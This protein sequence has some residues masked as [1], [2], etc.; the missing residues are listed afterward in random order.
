MIETSRTLQ[1]VEA[2]IEL[3][4]L[5]EPELITVDDDSP[6]WPDNIADL[7][8]DELAHHM[9]YWTGLGAYGR[10]HLARCETDASA[11]LEQYKHD[12]S[13]FVFKSGVGPKGDYSTVTEAKAVFDQLPKT[14]N[15]KILL[16]E[17]EAAVKILKGRIDGYEKKN[18]AISREQTR[19]EKEHAE[20]RFQV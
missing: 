16:L 19:R 8:P 3:M 18:A 2:R 14:I 15:I 6:V 12:R 5:P 13:V 10:N 11:W 7:T 17:A 9:T 4:G 20:S 1:K